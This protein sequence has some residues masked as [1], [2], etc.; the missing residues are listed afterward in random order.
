MTFAIRD[1]D[2]LVDALTDAA[3]AFAR[4]PDGI[5]AQK[6]LGGYFYV[7]ARNELSRLR[8]RAK[9]HKQLNNGTENELAAP[10]AVDHQETSATLEVRKIVSS[11]P[12]LEREIL[13]L[14]MA[15]GFRLEAREIAIALGTTAR[16]VHSLRNRTKGRLKPLLGSDAHGQVEP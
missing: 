5:D 6:N 3:L 14:D 1:D 10:L 7:A 4:R 13:C 15:Y 12:Q 11:L 9:W 16:T 2:L 8:K